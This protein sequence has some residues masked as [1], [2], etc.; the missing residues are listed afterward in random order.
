MLVDSTTLFILLCYTK[1]IIIDGGTT[2]E[3]RHK[4]K[5]DTYETR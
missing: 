1:T 5:D 2:Y 4:R 3:K